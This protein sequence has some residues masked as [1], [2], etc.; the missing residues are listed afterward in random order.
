M[1][2]PRTPM[3]RFTTS[4]AGLAVLA[5]GLVTLGTATGAEASTLGTCSTGTVSPPAGVSAPAIPVTT[6]TGTSAVNGAWVVE[7]PYGYADPTSPSQPASRTLLLWS[8]GFRAASD[9]DHAAADYPQGSIPGYAD[10]THYALLAQGYALAGSAYGSNGWAVNDGVRADTELLTT[11]APAE[12][13]VAPAHVYAWG[14]SL[15]GLITQMLAQRHPAL[16]DGSLPECG[17]LAGSVAIADK[18]LDAEAAAKVFFD[19]S[20][21]LRGY[22]SDAAATQQFTN[23]ENAVESGLSTPST[24][25][26][27]LAR[28]IGIDILLGLPLKTFAFNDQ[29]SQA[30]LANAAAESFL[31]QVGY[32]IQGERDVVARSGGL[33]VTN[34]GIDYRSLATAGAKQQFASYGLSPDLLT[35]Y[36]RTL[37]TY[38]PRVHDSAKA[39]RAFAGMGVPTGALHVPTL[40]MHTEDDPLVV[41]QHETVFAQKV[42]AHHD[43]GRLQQIFIA[44]PGGSAWGLNAS[45][46]AAAGE[47]PAYYGAGHCNFSPAQ[48]IAAVDSLDGWARSGDRPSVESIADLTGEVAAAMPGLPGTPGA[49]VDPAYVEQAWPRPSL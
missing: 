6:C 5:T 48:Q 43:S 1:L 21:R 23:V 20:L 11:I 38:A 45:T 2:R 49:A 44:P 17:V 31:T 12:L 24:Q 47:V 30:S 42:A 27:T 33:P 3:R 19:P 37:Q 32:G 7:E 22:S 10:V 46:P 39:R 16:V 9:T 14:E 36:A 35:A 15:G 41:V 25:A 8:H 13:S 26:A 34:I 28:L 29:H 4:L 40:T 18:F